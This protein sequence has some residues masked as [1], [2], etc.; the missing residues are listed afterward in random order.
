MVSFFVENRYFIAYKN[1][2]LNINYEID[3]VNYLAQNT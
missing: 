2:V 3:I 1:M